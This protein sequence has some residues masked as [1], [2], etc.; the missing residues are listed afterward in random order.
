MS[1]IEN[2]GQVREYCSDDA[3]LISEVLRAS[4][5]G[6]AGEFY[7]SA[8]VE[9]WVEVLPDAARVREKNR[10]GRQTFV[11]QAGPEDLCGFIDVEPDGHIDFLYV[12][13]KVAGQGF[14]TTL[15]AHLEAYCAQHNISRL[16]TEASEHARRF[17]LAKGFKELH[18]RDFEIAG[19]PIH[20]Y[21]MEKRIG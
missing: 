9:A 12:H 15:Y 2:K 19:V 17:F 14:A 16:Y 11:I 1:K 4:V 20:N 6:L 5:T 21:A 18:R 7:N 8:Q 10:D 13:P 3:S